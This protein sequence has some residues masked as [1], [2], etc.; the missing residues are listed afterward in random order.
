MWFKKS[1]IVLIL[2]LEEQRLLF[3][4]HEYNREGSGLGV[5]YC[6]TTMVFMNDKAHLSRNVFFSCKMGICFSSHSVQN[7]LSP[8]AE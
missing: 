8:R 7:S 5:Y 2:S 6:H 1:T 4:P 3:T